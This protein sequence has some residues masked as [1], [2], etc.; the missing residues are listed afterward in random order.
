MSDKSEYI[1]DRLRLRIRELEHRLEVCED[2]HKTD[3]RWV[4]VVESALFAV[5]V[6]LGMAIMRFL[7]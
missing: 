6:V 3:M 4:L 7:A 5:G 2:R 1:V